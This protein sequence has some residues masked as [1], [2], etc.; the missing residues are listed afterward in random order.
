MTSDFNFQHPPFD[1]LDSSQRQLLLDQLDIHYF[2]NQ[3]KILSAG[4]ESQF[5][6]VILKGE[7]EER[8][9]NNDEIF[10]HYTLDDCFD[11]RSQFGGYCKHDYVA[12][13]EC[14]CFALPSKVFRQLAEVN[15]DFADYFQNDLATRHQLV[16]SRE[17]NKNLAEF[18]LTT[19]DESNVQLA[20]V[21]DGDT[22]LYQATKMMREQ[23][24]ESLLVDY[25]GCIGMLTG[26]D[27]LHAAVLTQQSLDTPVSQLANFNLISVEQGE[28]LFNAMLLMTR[29]N[30]ERV[31]VKQQHK[32]V[33]IMEMAHLLSLFSTHSHVLALQIARADS[34]D[35]LANAAHT[36]NRLIEN[37][38]N[39]GIRTLF[40]MKLL[41]T[42]NEQ[43][44]ERVFRLCVPEQHHNAICL[45]VMG[46][47]G[48]GEQIVKTDQDNGLIIEDSY[49]WPE[50]EQ[51]LQAFSD[52]LL[53]LGYPPCPGKI[54]VNNPAWVKSQSDW[55]S[56][57]DSWVESGHGDAAMNMAIMFDAHA[58]AGNRSLLRKL[59]RH[60]IQ[61]MHQREVALSFFARPALQFSTPLTFLGNVRNEGIDIKKGGIFPIVHGVRAMA[62]EQGI[63]QT[64]T[65]ERIEQLKQAKVIQPEHAANLSEALLLFF[66]LRIQQLSDK[67]ESYHHIDV[68]NL[69]RG[70][71]DLLRHALHVVKK[72]KQSLA[73]HFQIRDY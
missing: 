12:L 18:I 70:Q 68:A 46:S 58:V 54:M 5:L 34:I 35:E 17:R 27:L 45:I 71:R 57:L 31:V 21:I 14:L 60:L 43:L 24:L 72:Y 62:L 26:T 3:E 65:L 47:E 73:H 8:A 59:K 56:T 16:E 48:R 33:G 2:Q 69:Q 7:V 25:D 19:I 52:A 11:I 6:F 49:D 32:V 55:T 4:Q 37:L 44:I 61:A 23:K 20:V 1:Q 53:K 22:S 63:E 42:M 39:N 51:Q 40:I 9:D 15:S 13:E 50:R 10:A 64:N 36:L 67:T 38:C 41:A 66:K 28:F 29:N 30:I